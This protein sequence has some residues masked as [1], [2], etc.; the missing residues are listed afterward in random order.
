MSKTLSADTV[1]PSLEEI[2]APSDRGRA[3]PRLTVG[4]KALQASQRRLALTMILIPPLG[5][6]AALFLAATT[7]FTI[8]E[9]AIFLAMHA[10]TTIGVTVGFH[11]HFAHR[12]FSA[13]PSVR[14]VLGALGSMAIQGPVIFW[15]ATHRRHHLH[16]DREGD[17][18]SPNLSGDGWKNRLEGQWH[19]HIRWLYAGEITNSARFANDLRRDPIAVWL[20][21]AYPLWAV[22][23]LILPAIAGALWIG[24]WIGALKGFLWGGMV[25]LFVVH[26]A[27]WSIGSI[28]HTFGTRP[29]PTRD[30]SGNSFWLA[31]PN[32]GEG[33][34]NNHHAFP[35][36][37]YFGLEWWQVDVGGYV[38]RA[39]RRLGGISQVKYPTAEQ[40]RAKRRQL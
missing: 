24:G 25:R 39:L 12:A 15:T 1:S 38:I 10:L 40:K 8:A 20:N 5:V 21:R 4:D 35:A 3:V 29:Y 9:V 14:L 11:R 28:A 7:G 36:S 33:W 34:H 27:F 2:P 30:S 31:V 32:F 13:R 23:G 37:A 22:L 19:A 18:H 16:S 6:A 26:H 17:P